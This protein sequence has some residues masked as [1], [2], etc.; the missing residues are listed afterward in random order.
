MDQEI[1][2]LLLVIVIISCSQKLLIIFPCLKNYPAAVLLS[3]FP[4]KN[5]LPGTHR[6][7]RTYAMHSV[8]TLKSCAVARNSLKQQPSLQTVWFLELYKPQWLA[9]WVC[10]V[11]ECALPNISN[12]YF[13]RCLFNAVLFVLL[14]LKWRVG[15]ITFKNLEGF[16]PPSPPKNPLRGIVP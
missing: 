2:R 8:S 14:H 5:S 16:V 3:T 15:G 7:M 4:H 9:F 1:N 12:F 10:T 11:L 6:V 13:K